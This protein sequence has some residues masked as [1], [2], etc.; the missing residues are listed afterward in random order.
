M[1]KL[2]HPDMLPSKSPSCY[3]AEKWTSL[4]LLRCAQKYIWSSLFWQR[5]VFCVCSDVS[6]RLPLQ[7]PL[8]Q[9]PERPHQLSAGR[10]VCECQH[11]KSGRA[12]RQRA[13]QFKCQRRLSDT[14]A[15]PTFNPDLLPLWGCC[16]ICWH[17]DLLTFIACTMLMPKGCDQPSLIHV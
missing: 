5:S 15:P 13:L 6:A 8:L 2:Q 10:W 3:T 1:E 11:S 17:L 12:R 4:M 14:G 16:I 9:I 7:Q